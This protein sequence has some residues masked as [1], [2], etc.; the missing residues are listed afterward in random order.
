MKNPEIPHP[1]TFSS[2][3]ARNEMKPDQFNKMMSIGL[4]QA[5]TG[6]SRDFDEAFAELEQRN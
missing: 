3:S 2:V 5:K 1:L 6:D 4:E